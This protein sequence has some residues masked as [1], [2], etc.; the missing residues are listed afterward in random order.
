MNYKKVDFSTWPRG[1]LFQ[2]YMDHMRV[3]MSLTVDMDVTPLVRFVK[4]RGMKFYPAM[5]WVV[6]RVINAHEEFKL[7]WDQDGNLIRWD[8]VSPSYAHFHPEDGN[9]TKLVTPYME[10]LSAVPRPFPGGPG[11]VPGTPGRGG[12]AANES[13][14]CV[15]SALGALPPLRCPCV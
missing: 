7:G 2:F 3:V 10:D 15:L 12:R 5:I 13:L 9:F 4:Q 6:S 11:E 1:D 8:F 14:R